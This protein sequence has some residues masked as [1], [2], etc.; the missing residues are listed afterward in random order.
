MGFLHV[1]QASLELLTSG[2]LSTLASQSAGITGVSHRAQ[3]AT[4]FFILYPVI[5]T[6][7]LT[8]LL[9]CFHQRKGLITLPWLFSNSWPPALASQNGVS[10]SPRLECSGMISAHCNLRL[11]G[12][13]DSP[14][15]DSQVAGITGTCH[16]AWLVFLCLVETGFYHVGQAGLKLLTSGDPT[17]LA[18]LSA[19]I[20]VIHPPTLQ[21]KNRHDLTV[22]QCS[23]T[24]MAHCS[25]DFPG[26]DN[27]H[28]LASPVVGT[29]KVCYHTQQIFLYFLRRQGFTIL[30]RLVLNS[31]AQ[32]I[33][34][35][36]PLSVWI[37]DMSHYL[38]NLCLSK[39]RWG[40]RHVGQA[41]LELLASSDLPS[42]DFQS[43][44]ITSILCQA[45]EPPCRASNRTESH[46]VAQAGVQWH[47][48]SSLQLPLPGFKGFSYFNLLSSWDYRC[49][50]PHPANFVFLVEMG[51]H[52]TESHS[53]ARQG[54]SGVILAH[55]NF[56]FSG[57]SDSPASAS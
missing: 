51:F 46:S 6:C 17:A 26:S 14:T 30:P 54:C 13:S 27:S 25:L 45:T 37:T 11:L 55:C 52:H 1:G 29:I 57:S 38:A 49:A 21:L 8:Q 47:N 56:Q 41:G 33:L 39:K 7:R 3:P 16:H 12:S 53:T 42:S 35:P 24:T 5:L 43:A 19:G 32:L 20:T 15:S 18:S 31:R 44:E 23:G 48:L 36:H 4:S 40:L 2:D 22:A 28:T 50:P 34:P 9:F 10:L